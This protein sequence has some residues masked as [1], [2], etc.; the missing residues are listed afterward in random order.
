MKKL[1]LFIAILCLCILP[2]IIISAQPATTD[3]STE[4]NQKTIDLFYRSVNENAHLYNGREYIM[5]D[6]RVKG[7]PYF[8]ALDLQAG[9]LFYDGTL[10][11][12]VPMLYEIMGEQVVIRQYNQGV[13]I[14]LVN[15]K[16]DYFNLFNHTFIHITPDS[17]NTVI[18]NGFYDRLY[19]GNT[20]VFAKR[21]KIIT[22]DP[23][24]FERSFTE[25]DRYFIYKSGEYH[26]VS[27]RGD[28][29]NVFK[30]KKKDIAKY[31]RQNKINFKK[32]P[33]YAM[34]KMAEY[35]DQLTH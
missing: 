14:T 33:E 35:Y 8:N 30:D 5:Y 18:S 17:S 28:I 4:N 11:Q 7:N 23:N 34:V 25:K 19:N 31:L 20:V 26:S 10:Y 22:E 32:A 16:I 24:T 29:L 9:S 27:D 15:E 12:N 1:F 6:P 2:G 3:S 13:L 21:Q